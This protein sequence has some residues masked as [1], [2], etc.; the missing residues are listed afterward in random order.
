MNILKQVL[1][2]KQVSSLKQL[3]ILKQGKIFNKWWYLTQVVTLEQVVMWDLKTIEYFKTSQDLQKVVIFNTRGD[4]QIGYLKKLASLKYGYFKIGH[5]KSKSV[6]T[7]IFPRGLM[8]PLSLLVL[9]LDDWFVSK[10][11]SLKLAGLVALLL[12]FRLCMNCGLSSHVWSTRIFKYVTYVDW[13][14]VLGIFSLNINSTI[15]F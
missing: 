5:W 13:F 11:D 3:N 4:T 2:L 7:S 12:S 14:E 10:M 6:L 9:L 1:I 15:Y 8:A